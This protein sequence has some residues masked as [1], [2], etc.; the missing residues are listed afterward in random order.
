MNIENGPIS[1]A[2]R[3]CCRL[4]LGKAEELLD[5]FSLQQST[6]QKEPLTVR[7]QGCLQLDITQHDGL[8]KW[9]CKQCLEKI[10][11]FTSFRERCKQ[12]E[13]KLLLGEDDCADVSFPVDGEADPQMDGDDDDDEEEMEM[14][15]IDPSQDY[16]SSNDSLPNEAYGVNNATDSYLPPMGTFATQPAQPAEEEDGEGSEVEEEEEEYDDGETKCDTVAG[17][18]RNGL[19]THSDSTSTTAKVQKTVVYTCKYCDVAFGSPS[20]CQLHEMQE[21]DLLA[22]YGCTYCHYK[23]SIRTYLITHIRDSHSLTRP[24]ICVQCNKGFLRRSDL[25]K[26]TF[27]HTGIRPYACDQ[28]SKSFSRNTNLKKHMRTHLGLKPHVC[29][30]CPRS[31]ANKADLV[32]HRSYHQEQEAQ[33]SC[34]RCGTLYAQKDKLYEHERYCTGK[35]SLYGLG[36]ASLAEATK[37]DIPFVGGLSAPILSLPPQIGAVEP[38]R[39]EPIVNDPPSF[40]GGVHSMSTLNVPQTPPSSKIY[41]CSKCPK[42]F[43]S[44]AS[45]RTHQM[46]HPPEDKGN[47]VCPQCSEQ[48]LVKR[49]YDRHLQSHP[50]LK[51]Y[52]CATCGKRFSRK[53][54][55]HRHERIHQPERNFS[56]PHCSAKF[57]RKEAFESHMRIHCNPNVEGLINSMGPAP[58]TD[59]MV[60]MSMQQHSLLYSMVREDG[61]MAVD[62]SFRM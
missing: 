6:E 53:D 43:L 60:P 62:P 50:E 26:H 40:D 39:I 47:Y 49:E 3:Q 37:H 30:L 4:C 14:I 23:T 19:P 55:L 28:C 45:L 58:G 54:K 46:I 35:S 18:M 61:T 5:I 57:V 12:N 8:P 16:E 31:F 59:M 36:V 21:H 42:R 20:A 44:K 38:N 2:V 33:Y 7:I 9:I 41:N 29:H 15:V 27:V 17:E 24:Y 1:S 32:R 10:D 56:C 13:R 25:K 11:D 22:P 52:E 51:P 34:I 48:F